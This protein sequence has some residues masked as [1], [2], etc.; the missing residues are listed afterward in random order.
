MIWIEPCE[1]LSRTLEVARQLAAKVSYP[2]KFRWQGAEF[3]LYP[4]R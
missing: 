4:K 1:S 3:I 2:V